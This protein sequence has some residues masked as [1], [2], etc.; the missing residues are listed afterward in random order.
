MEV[1]ELMKERGWS[2]EKLAEASE[3]DIWAVRVYLL[4]EP[5]FPKF[6]E[7]FLEVKGWSEEELAKRSG[8]SIWAV[9]M[10]VF[11]VPLYPLLRERF[12]SALENMPL[13][14]NEHVDRRVQQ[15]QRADLQTRNGE[16]RE[17]S[18]KSPR[19]VKPCKTRD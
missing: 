4:F 7:R 6:K 19:R 13:P 14:E 17:I 15:S 2:D 9:R 3:L 5:M 18:G 10:Y 16:K 1:S 12:L 8:L 11:F